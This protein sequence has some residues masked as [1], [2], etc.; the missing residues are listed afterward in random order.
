MGQSACAAL[1][2]YLTSQGLPSVRVTMDKQAPT[3]D[4]MSGKL[5]Q[6]ISA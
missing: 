2:G 5:R 6:I 1:R 4:V 3:V